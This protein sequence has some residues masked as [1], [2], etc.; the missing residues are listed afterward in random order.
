MALTQVSK[1]EGRTLSHVKLYHQQKSIS[2]WLTQALGLC[3]LLSGV[4][5]YAGVDS[6]SGSTA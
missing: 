4:S 1:I 2:T 3:T 6:N 5:V